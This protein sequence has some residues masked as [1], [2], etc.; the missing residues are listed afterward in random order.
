M[1][2]YFKLVEEIITPEKVK[3]AIDKCTKQSYFL[4]LIHGN[5]L[6]GQCAFSYIKEELQKINK[7]PML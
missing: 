2:A 7:E 5:A 3:C 1:P 4:F 6:C